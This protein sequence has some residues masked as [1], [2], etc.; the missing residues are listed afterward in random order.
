MKHLSLFALGLILSSG[1]FAATGTG[2]AQAEL[3][4]P[5]TVTNTQNIDF[6]TVAIDPAAGPQT[7]T[8]NSG[9]GD[10]VECPASYVCGSGQPG[11]I[12]ITAQQYANINISIVGQ[13]ATLSDGAGNTLVFDPKFPDGTDLWTNQTMSTTST[14]RPVYGSISFTGNEPA[15]VY[16]TTNAGGSGY[17]VTVNY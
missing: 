17:V 15:G 7:I 12:T 16:N 9:T 14:T 6:G 4:T 8:L 3:S 13:T 11:L 2:H 1:A 5:L 10:T